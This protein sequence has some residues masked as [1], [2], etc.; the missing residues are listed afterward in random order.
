MSWLCECVTCMLSSGNDGR[1]IFFMAQAEVVT[2][3]LVVIAFSG[4]GA[5]WLLVR[6]LVAFSSW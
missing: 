4:G 2:A 5:L 1:R 6:L 3:V